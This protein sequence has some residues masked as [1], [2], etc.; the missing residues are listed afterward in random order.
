ML[1]CNELNMAENEALQILHFLNEYW[2]MRHYS[3]LGSSHNDYFQK[4]QQTSKLN[5]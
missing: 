5:N 2:G 1:L 3:M 4:S